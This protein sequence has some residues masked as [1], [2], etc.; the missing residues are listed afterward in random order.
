MTT[1]GHRISDIGHR[2]SRRLRWFWVLGAGGVLLLVALGYEVATW[3]H[4]ARLATRN[5]TTTAFIEEYQAGQ[6]A[7]GRSPA[8]E[9]HPVPHE[10]IAPSLRRAVVSGEDMEFFFHHGFS[11]AEI[12][13]ALATAVRKFAI[14]RGAST[15]TQQ[16]AKNLWL[17]PSRNP[18][19]KLKEALLTIQLEHDLTKQRILDL[20]LNVAEF[21]PGIYGAEAAAEH[22]FGEP[23]SELTEEQ[24]G[25]LAAGLPRP[26]TWHPG[27]DSDGYRAYVAEIERRMARATFLWRYV[28][29]APAAPAGSVAAP[30][31]GVNLDSALNVDSIIK[32]LADTS[33][34]PADTDTIR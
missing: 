8:V 24:A 13:D 14:P 27:R 15:I 7:Q 33:L 22:Y 1:F 5:P 20:Y 31:V 21:G 9:W 26:S 6:R 2:S 25:E 3:P 12:K 18:L 16:L 10:Q 17:S 11:S 32:V 23:A 19:R 4:V 30:A 34:V 29:G 28:G